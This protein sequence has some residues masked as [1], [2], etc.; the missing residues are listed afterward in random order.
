AHLHKLGKSCTNL[1]LL[2][3]FRCYVL[4]SVHIRCDP[5]HYTSC[6][7]LSNRV[8]LAK[9]SLPRRQGVILLHQS[10]PRRADSSRHARSPGGDLASRDT[11][12]CPQYVLLLFH[13]LR[14]RHHPAGVVPQED[15]LVPRCGLLWLLPSVLA[16]H[17]A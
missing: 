14:V 2:G 6:P 10:L 15:I 12:G 9:L 17:S 3:E 13:A 8:C 4:Q 11:S 1:L 7:F 16:G 5:C